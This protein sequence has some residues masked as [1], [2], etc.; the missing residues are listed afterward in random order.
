MKVRT[1]EKPKESLRGIGQGCKARLIF[2]RGGIRPLIF[3]ISF[4]RFVFFRR[5]GLLDFHRLVIDE[6]W[7]FIETFV[8]GIILGPTQFI[9]FLVVRSLLKSSIVTKKNR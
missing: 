8:I 5:H 3:I 7:R 4:D 2:E 6:L 1:A 9:C